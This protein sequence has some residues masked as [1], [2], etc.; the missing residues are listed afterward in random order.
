[1]DLP[2]EG[3]LYLACTGD[4]LTVRPAD[5]GRALLEACVFRSGSPNV[6]ITVAERFPCAVP[7][8][9]HLSRYWMLQEKVTPHLNI[10]GIFDLL[11]FGV[12]ARATG[13]DD[14]NLAVMLATSV[15]EGAS[16]ALRG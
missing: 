10:Y 14:V 16:L 12:I 13:R 7:G 9:E 8:G 4:L 15:P 5:G 1:M 2:E 6:W 11:T 3:A